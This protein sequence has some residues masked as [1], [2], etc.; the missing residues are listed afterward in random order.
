MHME[1]DNRIEMD[2]SVRWNA[3][4]TRYQHERQV[5]AMLSAKGFETFLPTYDTFHK[6]KDRRKKISEALFPG[7]LFIADV[8]DRKIQVVTTPGVCAI[9]SVAG[10]PATIPEHEIEAIRKCVSDTGKVEPHP[11]L[12]GG[13]VVRVQNGPLSGVEGILVRKKDSCRL[14]VS[15]EILGRAAAVEI[16]AGCVSKA[17]WERSLNTGSTPNR[18]GAA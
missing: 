8:T 17:S 11:Y 15:V 3:L 6:W 1:Q 14:V 2:R 12:Q 10:T 16:D 7:Y 13:D 18:P 9:V 5:E 4:H